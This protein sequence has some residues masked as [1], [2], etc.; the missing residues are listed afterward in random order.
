MN[1]YFA[2][3]FTKDFWDFPPKMG[4]IW[5]PGGTFG[6]FFG[7]NSPEN[8]VERRFLTPPQK[9]GVFGL[10]WPPGGVLTP[11][12]AIFGHFWGSFSPSALKSPNPLIFWTART[13]S[14]TKN[15]PHPR[16]FGPKYI[17]TR[18]SANS[19]LHRT[20]L[21]MKFPPQKGGVFA[22]KPLF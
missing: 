3:G 2:R 21:T 8:D 9:R 5:V 15:D 22:P 18:L 10:F 4:Q 6:A 13:P 12:W 14:L 1:P 20:G 11:F 19:R 17:H 16:V 7:R